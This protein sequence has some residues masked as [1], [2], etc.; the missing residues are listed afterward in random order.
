VYGTPDRADNAVNG[1]EV[2]RSRGELVSGRL[3]VVSL[4]E[5]PHGRDGIGGPW[6][7]YEAAPALLGARVN[8]EHGALYRDVAGAV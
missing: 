2:P 6:N 7:G 5:R 8:H 1:A 3:A 4:L